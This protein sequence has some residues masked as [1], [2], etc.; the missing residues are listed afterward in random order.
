MQYV[1][2]ILNGSLSPRMMHLPVVDRGDNLQISR[3]SADSRQWVLQRKEKGA[4]YFCRYLEK[5]ENFLSIW[6]NAGFSCGELADWLADSF[7]S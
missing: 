3:I 5:A 1:L 4:C 6:V 2:S 7:I